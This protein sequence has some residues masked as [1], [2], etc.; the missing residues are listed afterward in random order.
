MADYVLLLEP[1]TH[2]AV[3]IRQAAYGL[4]EGTVRMDKHFFADMDEAA[5]KEEAVFALIGSIVANDVSY[6]VV[7]EDY[8]YV[9]IAVSC[10][11]T[12]DLKLL[13]H[14]DSADDDNS[15][16]EDESE[17]S[18]DEEECDPDICDW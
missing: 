15:D 11:A 6:E 10:D 4:I 7:Y 12:P 18:E 14:I 16:N 8:D 5:R 13:A 17:C 9:H 1:L 3:R 2:Y